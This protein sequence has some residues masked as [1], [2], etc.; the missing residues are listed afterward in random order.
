MLILYSIKLVKIYITIRINITIR[1]LLP[2]KKKSFNKFNLQFEDK[3][4]NNYFIPQ[5]LQC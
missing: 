4:H 5:L 3:L 1:I 2:K